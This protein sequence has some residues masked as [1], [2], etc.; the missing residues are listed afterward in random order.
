MLD[1]MDPIKKPNYITFYR[2]SMDTIALNCSVFEKI[3]LFLHFCDRQTNRQTYRQTD[4]QHGS[5]KPLSLL[6]AAA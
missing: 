4:E 5:T 6:R 2:S 1:L 3:A